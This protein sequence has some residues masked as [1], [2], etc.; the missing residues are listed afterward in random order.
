M[1]IRIPY[2]I[3]PDEVWELDYCAE[4]ARVKRRAL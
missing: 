1:A 3:D 4:V 2:G